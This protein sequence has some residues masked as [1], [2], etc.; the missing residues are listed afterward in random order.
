MSPPTTEQVSDQS[1]TVSDQSDTVSLPQTDHLL[2]LL[3]VESL[4][5]Q[6]SELTKHL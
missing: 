1:D 3:S 4:K 5:L 6:S 2:K